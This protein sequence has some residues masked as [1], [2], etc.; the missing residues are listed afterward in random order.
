MMLRTRITAIVSL[1]LLVLALGAIG[2]GWLRQR[3]ADARYADAILS[4]DRN[5][6]QGIVTAELRR[7]ETELHHLARDAAV[8]EAIAQADRRALAQAVQPAALRLEAAERAAAGLAIEVEAVTGGRLYRSGTPGRDVPDLLTGELLRLALAQSPELSGL[9]RTSGGDYRIAAVTPVLGRGG[10]TAL[11]ALHVPMV[12][13]LP[14]LGET[15]GA[16]ALIRARDGYFLESLSDRGHPAV[17]PFTPG[18]IG[19]DRMQRVSGTDGRVYAVT[20]FGFAD[21]LGRSIGRLVTVR[22]VTDRFYRDLLISVLSYGTVAATLMLLIGFLQWYMR[23]A[24]RPLNGVIRVLNALA[25][26]DRS[27]TFEVPRRDDEIGR[28]A[29]T[30][31]AFRENQLALD[32]ART[33]R[34]RYESELAIAREIQLNIVPSAFP[35]FPERTD[36]QLHAIMEPAKAVGGD[37]YDFFLID[38]RR[39]FFLIGDVSDKGVPS[40]LFM[41]IVRTLFKTTMLT[42]RLPLALAMN[43][44]NRFLVE[45][46][47]QAMFVTIFAGILDTRTGRI[48]YCDGGHEPPFLVRRGGAVELLSK[49]GGLALGLL[50]DFVYRPGAFQLHPNDAL[51][52]YTDGVTE[53]MNAESAMFSNEQIEAMLA[54]IAD[55]ATPEE[56]TR[57]ILAAVHDFTGLA[58]QSDDITL[59]AIRWLGAAEQ[60]EERSAAA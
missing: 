25:R 19:S 32:E 21:A 51:V 43:A 11:L 2:E 58:P 47:P 40:A 4:G 54:S 3:T 46:N 48:E 41:A 42:S 53:A 34:Q 44:V 55:D 60:Q 10:V 23:T 36:F 7:L 1:A 8:V 45:N 33:A 31:A 56:V 5:A 6:W 52:L 17:L 14:E 28:L 50:E 27:V 59:L 26:G 30:V 13:L 49:E 35:A 37:L 16:R 22:D 29:G 18:T 39:L 57:R 38:D 9:M 12:S 20:S 15:V 24:F